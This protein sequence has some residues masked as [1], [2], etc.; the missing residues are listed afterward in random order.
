MNKFWHR[1]YVRSM[2]RALE[3]PELEGMLPDG[4]LEHAA[5]VIATLHSALL[6]QGIEPTYTGEFTG[7]G[8]VGTV[9]R[10]TYDIGGLPAEVLL[11]R[12]QLMLR[13]DGQLRTQYYAN[14]PETFLGMFK[15]WDKKASLNTVLGSD[16]TMYLALFDIVEVGYIA[17]EDIGLVWPEDSEYQ[18]EPIP[19]GLIE[20]YSRQNKAE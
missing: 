10:R 2:D 12:R 11:G 20:W 7:W 1:P 3:R 9:A 8:L 13:E 15:I 17:D 4:A 16:P 6:D 18:L 19:S 14:D 5:G